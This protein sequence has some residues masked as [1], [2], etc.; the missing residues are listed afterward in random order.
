MDKLEKEIM[1][2][3]IWQI[4]FLLDEIDRLC[5]EVDEMIKKDK[6]GIIKLKHKKYKA[7]RAGDD[8][9]AQARAAVYGG[10][11]GSNPAKL[12]QSLNSPKQWFYLPLNSWG[13]F[14]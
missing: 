10:V 5:R 8:L 12:H 14:N 3:E 4:G 6:I 2:F 1:D 13:Y 11:A 9:E 7:K